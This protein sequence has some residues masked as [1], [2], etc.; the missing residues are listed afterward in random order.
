MGISVHYGSV[1]LLFS[2]FLGTLLICLGYSMYS[3]GAWGVEYG[4][5]NC[6]IN[7]HAIQGWTRKGGSRS[8]AIFQV[9]VWEEGRLVAVNVTATGP[10]VYNLGT[11]DTR[12]DLHNYV[13]LTDPILCGHAIGKDFLSF[14]IWSTQC[15][16]FCT[17][18]VYLDFSRS[19]LDRAQDSFSG[20][21]GTALVFYGLA[22]I[23]L[24]LILLKFTG[25][26]GKDQEY[27]LAQQNATPYH[28]Y[29]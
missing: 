17:Q 8:R 4:V 11:W 7:N 25:L 16:S 26:V 15:I 21:V 29:Q 27:E 28:E 10:D 2:L 22:I 20:M 13:N 5:Y 1:G 14:P 19:T 3:Q 12:E 9:D 18:L 6:T 24:I 23:S